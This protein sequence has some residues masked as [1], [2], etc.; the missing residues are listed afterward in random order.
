MSQPP[1]GLACRLTP[2][3]V[4]E[5]RDEL[6]P[7]LREEAESVETTD[8]GVRWRFDPQ[9]TSVSRIASVIDWERSCCSFLR[10]RLEVEPDGGPLVLEVTGPAGT[11]EL[12]EDLLEEPENQ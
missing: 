7:G 10:F 6:L 8:R 9:R 2:G 5:R 1:G 4:R 12:L 11:R 3:E